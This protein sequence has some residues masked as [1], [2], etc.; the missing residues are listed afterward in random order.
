VKLFPWLESLWRDLR[1]GT[2][3]LRKDAVVSSAA[4]VSLGLAIGACTAAFSL[5]D[6]LILRELPVRDPGSLVY[7]Q[8]PG[9]TG[10]ESTI[11]SYPLFD[12][13]RQSTAAHM[14]AFSTSPQ[15]L[16]QAILADAGG[17]EEKLRTQFVSGNAL[18]TLGVKASLGRIL[19]PED[20]VTPGGHP[21]AVVSHAFWTRRLGA[22][23]AALG[24][25]IQIEQ[26]S[27]QIV[28]SPARRDADDER[29]SRLPRRAP[30][31]ARADVRGVARMF[32]DGALRPRAGAPRV[33][34]K[35]R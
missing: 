33:G 24:Q 34:R 3:L 12:R 15:S 30:G 9:E 35:A 5:V 13:I 27:Y 17:I 21:V 32:H 4:V 28:G 19:G 1:L 22:N 23:P 2:R 20:D 29:E 10:I 8:P 11:V 7:F 6:A 14:E 18:E 31:L 16:R 25:W 26:R